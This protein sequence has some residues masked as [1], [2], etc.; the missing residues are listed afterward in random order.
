M[1]EKN[2]KLYE[3]KK[4]LSSVHMYSI[5]IIIF[6]LTLGFGIYQYKQKL[7]YRQ[8]LQNRFQQAFYETIAYVDNVDKLLAKTKLTNSPEQS[9]SIF[10][11]IWKEAS[12]AQEN[13]GE[14]PYHHSSVSSAL[15]F[16]S[17]LS[18]FSFSMTNK[19]IDGFKLDEEDWEKVSRLQ[20]YA[21]T[22]SNELN[23][24]SSEINDGNRIDWEE[25]EKAGE[26]LAM[27]DSTKIIGSISEVSKQ[28]QDMP[29]LIYDGPFSDHIERMEPRMTRD[30]ETITKEEGEKI[31]ENFIG[32]DKISSI[33]QT[34]ETDTKAEYVIPVY[35]Y[36]VTLKDQEDPTIA[37][38]VTKQGGYVLWMLNYTE[39]ESS[40]KKLSLEEARKKA[41]E[42][43]EE[44]EYPNMQPSYYEKVDNTVVINFAPKENNV[45]MY[46]DLIKVKVSMD[47]GE[48]IGFESL[49]YIMMHHDRD[50]PEIKI[51]EEEAR[52]KIT[53][54]FEIKK[55]NMAVIPLESKR[56]VFCYEFKGE[57]ENNPFIVYINVESGKEEK[58]LQVI[59]NEN[60]VLTQ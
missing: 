59:Q 15:K 16:L 7:N 40:D 3:W 56:E 6:A 28:F 17:Q 11:Q 51:S 19:A 12:S 25:I 52:S 35:S 8:Y 46:P 20:M 1:K 23:N 13:L 53:T 58:I 4:R 34:G 55:V 21:Q 26:K 54:D 44:K 22:L 10:A 30:K 41:E 45:I 43:L 31:V 27:D 24:I 32:K 9:A 39:K 49:G 50:L 18:D 37:I 42:F 48:I 36:E 14:L 5:I 33:K 57:Y 2:N 47:D 29:T 60:S 38:D